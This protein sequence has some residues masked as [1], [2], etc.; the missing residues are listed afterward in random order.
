MYNL[1]SPT[2]T[3]PEPLRLVVIGNGMAGMRTVEELLQARGRAPLSHH[4]VRRRA[5]R[6]LQPHHAVERARRRQER[7][8]RSSS[9][10]REWYDE[11]G[12]ALFAGD[13]VTAID[14]GDAD[15]HRRKR[16]RRAL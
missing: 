14:R 4:R 2:G 13:A 6:Q 10:R 15:R 1:D 12:I 3:G 9:I 7:W 8:M 16:P 5:A 11:N